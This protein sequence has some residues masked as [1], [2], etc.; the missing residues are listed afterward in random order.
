MGSIE[1]MQGGPLGIALFKAD[2]HSVHPV[3]PG[4]AICSVFAKC[5]GTLSVKCEPQSGVRRGSFAGEGNRFR[6][7]D[8]IHPASPV[9][10]R[11]MECFDRVSFGIS[12][13]FDVRRRL[14]RRKEEYS[15]LLASSA[16]NVC[17]TLRG[18]AAF[19]PDG[20]IVFT[21]G[22]SEMIICSLTGEKTVGFPGMPPEGND[23]Y[24]QV[25]ASADPRIKSAQLRDIVNRICNGGVLHSF[26]DC[27]YDT[28]E[29]Y[30]AACKLARASL[31]ERAREII[32]FMIKTY[33]TFGF[34]PI[35]HGQSVHT[36]PFPEI[37]GAYP[38]LAMKEYYAVT[39]D[40]SFVRE[41]LPTAAKALCDAIPLIK[42][43]HLPHMGDEGVTGKALYDPSPKSQE[44]F[45]LA[46][47]GVIALSEEGK[48]RISGI[49]RLRNALRDMDEPTDTQRLPLR[50]IRTICEECE[51][52]SVCYLGKGGRYLCPEC[53]IK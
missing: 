23:I 9:F 7:T 2:I 33:D 11:E 38:A 5:H 31:Y 53:Y 12:T 20:C 52:E 18:K 21:T 28:E 19:S 34:L 13:P 15:M 17:I 51:K 3:M 25:L 24:E 29:Q 16:G 10:V 46:A 36:D 26:A 50:A 45:A 37:R 39:R 43:G 22:K 47:K 1:Y 49:A 6:F 32:R 30:L 14:F 42:G 48:I 27:S 4:D 40:R 8:F 44:L 35:S 41:V